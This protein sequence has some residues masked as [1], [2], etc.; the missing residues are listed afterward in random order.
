MRL[1]CKVVGNNKC[2][3]LECS[4]VK[5]LSYGFD[6]PSTEFF[7]QSLCNSINRE[8]DVCAEEFNKISETD[9]QYQI[10]AKRLARQLSR[11]Q[12]GIINVDL[13]VE[14]RKGKHKAICRISIDESNSDVR[15]A[16]VLT[17]I[18]RFVYK[19][20]YFL[21]RMEPPKSM[22]ILKT[23]E[24]IRNFNDPKASTHELYIENGTIKERPKTQKK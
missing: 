5:G 13:S 10:N 18:A 15:T 4:T 20:I 9:K 3:H 16:T 8:I 12:Y 2:F 22:E 19:T 6:L 1:I 11:D 24:I 7:V 14:R 21:K 23:M 17:E